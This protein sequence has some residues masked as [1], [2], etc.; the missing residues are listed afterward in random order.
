[1]KV[2]RSCNIKKELSGFHKYKDSL[3]GHRNKCKDCV[4]GYTENYRD[5]YRD[6]INEKWRD[7]YHSRFLRDKKYYVYHLPNYTDNTS[8][9]YVGC[10]LNMYGR[11]NHHRYVGRDTSNF[12]V[13]KTFESYEEALRCETSYHDRGY[14]GKHKQNTYVRR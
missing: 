14:D 3:D 5:E 7:R 10:T 12:Y 6:E 2:C 8:L 13:I 9:G 11:I 1:M 4:K